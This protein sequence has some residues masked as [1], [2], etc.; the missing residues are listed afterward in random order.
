MSDTWR[1][2]DVTCLLKKSFAYFPASASF[3]GILPSSS[4]HS[5]RWSSSRGHEVPERGSKSWSPV[6]ASNR[7][8]ASDQMSADVS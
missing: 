8:H 5:A 6:A 2:D 3:F 1:S 7:M 4:M